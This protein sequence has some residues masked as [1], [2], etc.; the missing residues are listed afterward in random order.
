V[1]LTRD[2]WG[3]AHIHGHTDA[4]AVFGMVYSQ[5]EDDF[6]RI[7]MNYL[8]ALGRVAEAEGE[9]ALAQ[10]LRARLYVDPADLRAR[11]AASPAWLRALM[12]A[13]AAGLNA[14][15]ASHPALKPKVLTHFE[16]WM[17]LAFSEGSIGGDIEDIDLPAL[18]AF[19][20]LKKFASLEVPKI[21]AG[22]REPTGSNGIAIAPANTKDHHAL[23]LINPHT[24]FYFRAELQMTSDAGLNAYGAATWGQ[25]FLYQGFSDHIGWMHTSTTADAVD[26]FSETIVRR[27]DKVLAKYGTELRPVE[28]RRVTL[29]YRTPGG[30]MA[31][32]DYITW[33]TSHGPVVGKTADGHWLAEAIMFRP[34]EALEQS[35][36]LT[37]AVDFPGFM[38]VMALQANTSNNTVYADANGTIAFLSP[39]FIPRR[40]DRYDYTKPV[41]GADPRADWHGLYALTDLPTVVNPRE[42]WIQNTNNWP[43]SAAGTD[44]PVAAKYPRVLD[45]GG[46]NMRGVHA[47]LLLRG[48][49]DFTLSSLVAAAYDSRLTGFNLLIPHLLADYDHTP[50]TDP[51]RA[52]IAPQI[53]LL[54][55]WDQR[56]GV[57]SVPTSLAITWGEALF[58]AVG[59]STHGRVA[60]YDAVLAHTTPAQRLQAVET[61]SD[62]LTHDF[63]TWRIKWGDINRF[64]RLSDDIEGHYDDAKPS[65]PV[66]FTASQWGSLAAFAGPRTPGVKKR[67]GDDGNSFVAVVEFSNPVHA[68]AVSA[69]GESGDPGSPHFL[70]QASLYAQGKLRPVYFTPQDVTAHSVRR[71]TLDYKP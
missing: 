50:P 34:V 31:T 71:Y 36:L 46:E 62:T 10:D 33:R 57:D 63:G 58:H 22:F 48:R 49:R 56:W 5:A 39:Q 11:Y 60:D 54:R 17:A 29:S 27:G 42:G 41:D 69:G 64:Q 55:G 6:N 23:L 18:S 59:A 38:K 40:D 24:S 8:T 70:D 9:R 12:D 35:Y 2:E 21:T 47:Q 20:G 13:W 15:L 67:Y 61:A 45:T 25:F 37:K 43:Y 32:R 1:T 65:L 66:G 51:I 44:S 7:E 28:S 19:Y 52:R 4:D 53:A 3:I 14:F 30:T 16:P 68:V 26:Q